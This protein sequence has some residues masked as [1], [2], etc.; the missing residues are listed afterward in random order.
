MGSSILEGLFAKKISEPKQV[1][2]YDKI[3]EKSDEFSGRTGVHNCASNAELVRSV[4]VIVLAVKPQDLAAT[5]GEIAALLTARHT[6]ISILA[7]TPIA[8][9]KKGLGNA[10]AIIRAMPNLG[11]KVGHS[12]TALA[13]AENRPE[14]IQAAEQLFSGCGKTVRLDE[15]YFD[16]VTAVSGSGPA[17]FFLMMEL[18]V[19]EAVSQGLPEEKARL[20]AVETALGSAL[21]AGASSDSPAELRK[22][23]TS[24]GGTTEAALN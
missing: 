22:K 18:L 7:G 17:Y 20:L 11:A 2:I 4:E 16:L 8:K 23:V 10:C 13:G 19:E 9:I 3:K 5:A 6:V 14:A 1:W 24:K 15:K 21:L 12:V